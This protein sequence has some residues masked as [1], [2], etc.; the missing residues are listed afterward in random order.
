MKTADDSSYTLGEIY[1]KGKGT[2][3]NLAEAIKYFE[4][5]A[6]VD[7][8]GNEVE[9]YCK[10][11]AMLK[12]AEIYISLRDET[13]AL[14]WL[15]RRND[16]NK[17][18]AMSELAHIYYGDDDFEYEDASLIDKA[19]AFD[20]FK[21]LYELKDSS[22]TF[23]FG[24]MCEANSARQALKIYRDGVILGS[25]KCCRR[26]MQIYLAEGDIPAAKE[27]YKIWETCNKSPLNTYI[28]RDIFS[29][30]ENF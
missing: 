8:T 22:G 16:G 20:W 1:L 18:F 19:R 2:E 3:K 17:I 30:A 7:A 10:W 26:A 24:E 25:A 4:K 12:L 5:A 14:D 11:D 29:M 13:T 28:V 27:I 9:D 21:K 6:Q 23:Y 15:T